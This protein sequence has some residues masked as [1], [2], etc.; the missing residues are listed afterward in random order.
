[1][2]KALVLSKFL[3]LFLCLVCMTSCK[4]K[5]INIEEYN[6]VFFEHFST[7][8][9]IVNREIYDLVL[10]YYDSYY[11]YEVSFQDKNNNE[12]YHIL[13]VLRYGG[14]KTFFSIENEEEAKQY[15]G[16]YYQKYMES[17]DNGKS[18]KYSNDEINT[19]INR[20]YN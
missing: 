11:F 13:Y 7:K 1:M 18:K 15:F 9:D 20:Y 6:N 12:D 14:F 17:R 5:E 16:N 4:T 2:T 19:L 10:Y 3:I 8:Q